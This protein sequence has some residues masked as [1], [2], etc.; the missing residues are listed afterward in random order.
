MIRSAALILMR[1]NTGEPA[2]KLKTKEE[3]KVDQRR[4]QH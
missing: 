2:L 4:A 3:R 1:V